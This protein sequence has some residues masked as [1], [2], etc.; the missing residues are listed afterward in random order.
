MV[1]AG[2]LMVSQ[3]FQMVIVCVQKVKLGSVQVLRNSIWGEGVPTKRHGALQRQFLNNALRNI[4][5][6]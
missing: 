5:L 6:F 3:F 1:I 2:V 4:F